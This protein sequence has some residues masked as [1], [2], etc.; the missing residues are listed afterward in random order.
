MT[1][2]DFLALP[3]VD[4]QVAFFD[5]LAHTWDTEEQNP[6]DIVRQLE[7]L[8]DLLALCPGQNLLEVGCGTGYIT[9]GL[10]DCVRPGQI[11]AID[12]SEKMLNKARGRSNHGPTSPK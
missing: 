11:T 4:P 7:N 8:R 3:S 10:A 6:E 12:F 2:K 5:N 9:R 1:H